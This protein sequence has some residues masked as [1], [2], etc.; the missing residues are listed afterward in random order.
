MSKRHVRLHGARW[1]QV[2]R[3]VLERDGYRCVKCGKAGRL[4]VD[5]IQPLHK[6]GAPWDPANLQSLCRDCHIGKTRSE[7]YRPM[8]PDEAAW[9]RL[10]SEMMSTPTG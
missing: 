10:V 8:T 1:A 4:E 6:G 2:R 9:R 7:N 3:A 5:H